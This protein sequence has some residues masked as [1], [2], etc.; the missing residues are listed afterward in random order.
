MTFDTRNSTKVSRGATRF[1]LTV[2]GS[3]V[4]YRY[5]AT[6]K[7][8]ER[9]EGNTVRTVFRNVVEFDVLQN[10]SDSN[11][12]LTFEEDEIS[13]ESIEFE[14]HN[15]SMPDSELSITNFTFKIRNS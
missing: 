6:N 4:V 11:S 5:N 9:K 7:E 14:K 3:N 10:S 2:D 15:G 1:V 8:V 13:I 12:T